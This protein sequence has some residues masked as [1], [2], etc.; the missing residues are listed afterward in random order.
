MSRRQ[1]KRTIWIARYDGNRD[2]R[3]TELYVASRP[4]VE[5]CLTTVWLSAYVDDERLLC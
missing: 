3:E 2:R 4:N 5:E 1:V